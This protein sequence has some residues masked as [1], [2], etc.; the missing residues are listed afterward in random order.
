VLD[1]VLEYADFVAWL[2]IF[3]QEEAN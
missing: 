1:S 2:D 3:L